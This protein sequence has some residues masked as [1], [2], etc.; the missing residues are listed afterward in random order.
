[1]IRKHA[2]FF[3]ILIIVLSTPILFSQEAE[4]RAVE[5][6]EFLKF[7]NQVE[8]SIE[9]KGDVD[10]ESFMLFNPNRLA[11]DLPGIEKVSSSPNMDVNEMGITSIRSALHNPGLVRI[12]IDFSDKIPRY[13]IEET[14][15]GLK[16]FFWKEVTADSIPVEDV[17]VIEK[18]AVIEE[19]EKPTPTPIV[20][21]T[22]P[23]ELEEEEKDKPVKTDEEIRKVGV[24]VSV[25]Y[26]ALQDEVFQEVYGSGGIY[27]NA[28]LS[29]I[30]PIS[31]RYLDVWAGVSQF[32]SDGK[33]TAFE[34][35]TRLKIT[36][37]SLALR[38]LI[39][40]AKLTP[41][42]GLGLDYY[43]YKET[44][45]EGFDVPSV[46]GYDLGFH[47]QGGVYFRFTPGFFA[48]LFVK[49][50]SAKTTEN[51][52]DVNLGGMEYALGL[53]FRFN[54]ERD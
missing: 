17:E 6:I 1:M 5:N 36:V 29:F 25:G 2:I 26:L 7:E 8:V 34:E 54:L 41:F 12:V 15:S 46:G 24:G 9:Y 49:Y 53:I 18:E 4:A 47:V 50:N 30:L 37:F 32:Q 42:F 19:P 39:Q 51:N 44:L 10:F 38:Y 40:P 11:V 35:D 13:K 28:E 21:K 48:K 20:T 52:I 31:Y 45:P 14:E 43:S 3:L 33:S 16:I 27:Y 22:L 23:Q